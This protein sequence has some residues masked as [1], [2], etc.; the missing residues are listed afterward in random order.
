MPSS[1]QARTVV[2]VCVLLITAAVSGETYAQEKVEPGKSKGWE[3]SVGVGFLSTPNYTGDDDTQILLI[4]NVRSTDGEHWAISYREGVQYTI[5]PRKS[6][7]WGL[8]LTPSLGRDSDGESPFRISGDGTDDLNGLG[9]MDS[10]VALR[11]FTQ[12][13]ASDWSLDAEAQRTFNSDALSTFSIGLRRSGKIKTQGPPLILSGGITIR[14]GNE[15]TLES[16]VGITAEQSVLSNLAPYSPNAG[17]I[18][19]GINGTVVL[20]L[21]QSL[22]IITTLSIE[23]LGSELEGSS[24]V[25]ERGDKQQVTAGVFFSYRLGANLTRR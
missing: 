7:Q 21:S 1:D 3:V 11:V 25:T 18:G 15:N 23:Q 9:D 19:V 24:L 17:V 6:W 2:W 12:Y 5:N 10:A 14:A 20:P 8:A 22:R 4:P 16:L 13:K